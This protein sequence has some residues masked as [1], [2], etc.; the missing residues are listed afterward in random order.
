MLS[1]KAP[2]PPGYESIS[3]SSAMAI[4]TFAALPATTHTAADTAL[5]RT[6]SSTRAGPRTAA[7][8]PGRLELTEEHLLQGE[9]AAVHVDHRVLDEPRQQ[10]AQGPL[11]GAA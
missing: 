9:L 6:V 1:A 5:E 11:G 8:S 3:R 10:R 2:A 4:A 7:L